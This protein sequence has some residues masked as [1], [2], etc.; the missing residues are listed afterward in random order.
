MQLC[1]LTLL[2]LV[3][4]VASLCAGRTA[5]SS[6]P[7]RLDSPALAS[8][9]T[10]PHSVQLERSTDVEERQ[11]DARR[12]AEQDDAAPSSSVEELR[13][14]DSGS[15]TSSSPKRKRCIYIGTFFHVID[16]NAPTNSTQVPYAPP[17][18]PE[19]TTS[20]ST[21]ASRA[22]PA[23]VVATGLVTRTRAKA[24]ATSNV[25]GG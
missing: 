16:C 15:T 13:A 6:S 4:L 19:Q 5:P 7:L 9:D 18:E 21:T 10:P 24:A 20:T 17:R 1:P 8:S 25:E 12:L 2:G 3:A 11:L 23:P 22:G 14:L